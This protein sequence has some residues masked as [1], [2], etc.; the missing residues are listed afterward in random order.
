MTTTDAVE[1][2]PAPAIKKRSHDLTKR[3]RERLSHA[4]PGD[5]FSLPGVSRGNL[6]YLKKKLADVAE[7]TLRGSVIHIT[8]ADPP[9][10][11]P[12]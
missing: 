9:T 10:L 12:E 4:I 7:V 3:L 6:V 8:R 5:S 11:N 1:Q 2:T